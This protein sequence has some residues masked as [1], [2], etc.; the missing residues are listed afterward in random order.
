MTEGVTTQ[1]TA[2]PEQKASSDKE[3]NFRRLEEARNHDREERIRVETQNQMLQN[4]LNQIKEYMKPKEADP[5]DDIEEYIDPELKKRLEAKFSNFA[6]S[7]E[8]KAA[9]TAKNTYQEI[10]NKKKEADDKNF[11]SKLQDKYNDF[12]EVMSEQNI[13]EIGKQKPAFLKA[14]LKVPS[15]FE[16]REDL[17]LEIKNSKAAGVKTPT[18]QDRVQA[19]QKNPYFIPSG[20][21]PTSNAIDFDLNAPGAREAAYQKLKAAKKGR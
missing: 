2:E 6:S 18:V 9:E 12:D 13:F 4:E 21:A 10:Q 14:I 3:L 15:E 20:S 11:M 17:Y 8:R 5:F 19:N 1:A 7:V 16:K